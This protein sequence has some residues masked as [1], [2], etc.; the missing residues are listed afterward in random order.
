MLCSFY[1]HYVIFQKTPHGNDVNYYVSMQK[2]LTVMQQLHF[3]N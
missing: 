1:L 3:F 2:N